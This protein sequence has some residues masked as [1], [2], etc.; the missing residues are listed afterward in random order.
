MSAQASGAACESRP[1]NCRMPGRPHR[2]GE[3]R[4]AGLW[5]CRCQ[6][7]H[8]SSSRCPMLVVEGF[9]AALYPFRPHCEDGG[10]S[11]SKTVLHDQA[12]RDPAT[13]TARHEWRDVQW[14]FLR[15]KS[16]NS[17]KTSTSRK[18]LSRTPIR[19]GNRFSDK[20]CGKTIGQSAVLILS[21]R[22]ALVCP[23]VPGQDLVW[24]PPH[25]PISRVWSMAGASMV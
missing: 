4:P 3:R 17:H 14:L 7:Y 18:S 24:R 25:W 10:R 2:S 23:P 21:K 8:L 9:D 6:C 20:T 22:E 12:H 16:Q 19:D 13:A 1:E 5:K 11:H 15:R